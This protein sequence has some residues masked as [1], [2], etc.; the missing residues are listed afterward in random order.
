MSKQPK[1]E[2][3]KPY[4]KP[5]PWGYKTNS[6]DIERRNLIV[7]IAKH[8]APFESALDIGAGEG[9]ITK[10]LP[11][12]NLYGYEL[13]DEAANRFPKYVMRTLEPKG[14][15]DLVVATGVLYPWYD[16]E[17]FVDMINRHAS[18]IVLVSSMP[19]GECR[20]AI[21]KINGKQLLQMEFPYREHGQILRVFRMNK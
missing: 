6:D 8:Y 13:S 7:T 1:S 11:A 20:E 3:L 19:K 10:E 9:W 4:E 5:D 16:W 17:I 21:E 12:Y 15:Y 18:N 14:E 2:I